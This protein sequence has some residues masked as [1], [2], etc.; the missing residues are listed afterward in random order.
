MGNECSCVENP[1]A[2]NKQLGRQTEIVDES[3][4]SIIR[5]GIVRTDLSDD[6][7]KKHG[8]NCEEWMA[9]NN[10]LSNSKNFN[11][12]SN[13]NFEKLV[14]VK[15]EKD[16]L[17][18]ITNVK[19]L[20]TL[21]KL[22]DFDYKDPD[23]IVIFKEIA[24]KSTPEIDNIFTNK[25]NRHRIRYIIKNLDTSTFLGR[26]KFP[27]EKSLQKYDKSKKLDFNNGLATGRR[28]WHDDNTVYQGAFKNGMFNGLGRIIYRNG[29][30]YEGLFRDGAANGHGDYESRDGK[31]KY[32]G[33]FKDTKYNGMGELTNN[34]NEEPYQYL[35]PFVDGKMDGVDG[36]YETDS[37]KY[38]GNFKNG[39]FN[40]EKG[41][42]IYKDGQHRIEATFIDGKQLDKTSSGLKSNRGNLFDSEDC[43][44][45]LSNTSTFRQ[46]KN[47]DENNKKSEIQANYITSDY[48]DLEKMRSDLKSNKGNQFNSKD[49]KYVLNDVSISRLKKNDEENNSKK[50]EIQASY[51]NSDYMFS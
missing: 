38:L 44:Y 35:G 47:V 27:D 49:C 28:I 43:K 51:V 13:N 34:R 46:K 22:P 37:Y 25:P 48:I 12:I 9:G 11:T 24:N 33:E 19:V 2:T 39:L 15:E 7:L 5:H 14:E 20:Q 10:T 4:K 50:S 17:N 23:I 3:R 1:A 30:F 41:V 8:D 6:H 31:I 16:I 40:D 21:K 32:M 45:V 42:M 26:F 18:I 36:H 29:D